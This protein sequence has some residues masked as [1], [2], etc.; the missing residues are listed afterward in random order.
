MDGYLFGKWTVDDWTVIFLRVDAERCLNTDNGAPRPSNCGI[1]ESH[2]AQI[3]PWSN[4]GITEPHG[5]QIAPWSNRGIAESH[6]RQ[7]CVCWRKDTRIALFCISGARTHVLWTCCRLCCGCKDS[8]AVHR[9][10]AVSE[11]QGQSSRRH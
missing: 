1:T 10:L 6:G 9:F 5:V 11:V 4:R 8:S 3:V 2:G 7:R